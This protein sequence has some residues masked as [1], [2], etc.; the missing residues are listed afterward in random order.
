MQSG[1]APIVAVQAGTGVGKTAIRAVEEKG[2]GRLGGGSCER[3]PLELSG[4]FVKTDTG[5]AGE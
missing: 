2:T 5:A 3:L 1:K 4:I